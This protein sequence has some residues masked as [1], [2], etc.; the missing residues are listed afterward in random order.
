MDRGNTGNKF[1]TAL[2]IYNCV[3]PTSMLLDD[4][5]K[6]LSE[7]FNVVELCHL[8][9][10]NSSPFF[11]LFDNRQ[12]TDNDLATIDGLMLSEDSYYDP[13][14]GKGGTP[15]IQFKFTNTER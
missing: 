12:L 11:L 7:S 8:D 3:E 9:G 6:E 4:A 10:F 14:G 5:N 13:G 2:I 15:S 1:I